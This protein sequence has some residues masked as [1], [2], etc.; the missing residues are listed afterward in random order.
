MSPRDVDNQ[1]CPICGS[2]PFDEERRVLVDGR[3]RVSYCSQ[4]CLRTGV[5]KRQLAR[6]KTQLKT[7]AVA[8]SFLLAAAGVGWVRHLVLLHQRRQAPAPP[9][10]PVV[11]TAAP[12]P[13]PFGPHWPPTDEE[14]LAEFRQAAWVYPLPGPNRRHAVS[15]AKLVPLEPLPEKKGQ[16]PAPPP[17]C[18]DGGGCGVDLGGELWGEHVYAAHDG[19]VDRLQRSDDAPGGVYVRVAHWGGAVFTHYFH[20][21]AVPTRPAVGSRVTAGE[22]IG[23]V[24]DTGLAEPH[25]HLRFALSVRPSSGLAEIFW[26]P[27]P[28]MSGWPLRVPSRGSVAALTAPEGA[29]EAIAG[30]PS[31]VRHASLTRASKSR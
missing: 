21:A 3:T 17:R 10:A 14:W 27:A 26:D 15:A 12:E 29:P 24:G 5:R 20:L 8:L 18:R 7:A 25:P 4:A 16:P 23:R 6:R 22:V 19:V 9:P 13:T 28:L 11:A 30:A 2:I 1:A 31:P